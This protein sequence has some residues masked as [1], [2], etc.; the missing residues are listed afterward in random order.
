[1]YVFAITNPL[2]IHPTGIIFPLRYSRY[3]IFPLNL[4]GSPHNHLSYD[5]LALQP[6]D[7]INV[8]SDVDD[9]DNIRANQTK[10]HIWY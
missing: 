3:I 7:L 9:D 1:M 5:C 8:Y 2:A 10:Q 4:Y 6:Q